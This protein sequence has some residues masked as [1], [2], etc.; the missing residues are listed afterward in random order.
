MEIPSSGMLKNWTAAV[1]ALTMASNVHA[2]MG[3]DSPTSAMTAFGNAIE[4]NSEAKLRS[5]FGDDFRKL[6]PPL[7]TTDREAFIS[8]WMQSHFVE[9]GVAGHAHIAVGNAGWTFPIPLVEHPDGWHFDTAAGAEEM[10]LRRIGRNELAVIQTM[11]AVYDAQREYAQTH[12]DDNRLL[13]YASKLVS[14]QGKHDGLYW[15]DAPGQTPSPLGQA[16]VDAIPSNS[17]DAGFHGYFFKLLKSQG[18]HAPGGAY[19]Y[20]V[21]GKL[22]GGFAVIAWPVEYGNTG[23]KSFIVSHDGQVYQADLGLD[24]AAKA[25]A[26]TRFDPGPAW[27]RVPELD[28][29]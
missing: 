13:V 18:I 27:A 14:S 6:I 12:H 15:P 21:R 8:A 1:L 2:Q 22:F 20:L 10:R 11:L 26:I 3:F 4:N 24:T 25:Q 5:L 23:I 28:S 29:E 19:D 7:G 9:P 17:R 16:F